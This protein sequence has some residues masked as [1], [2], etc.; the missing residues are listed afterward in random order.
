MYFDFDTLNL[1][2]NVDELSMSR[3]SNLHLCPILGQIVAPRFDDVFI[4]GIYRGNIKSAEFNEF[5]PD[6]ISE[7]KGMTDVGL[8][9]VKINIKVAIKL[10]AVICDNVIHD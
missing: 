9:S 8:F 10:S 4:I 1:Y 6:K 2:N 7:I 3:S 5:S